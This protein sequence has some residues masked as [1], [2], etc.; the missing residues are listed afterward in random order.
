M[1]SITLERS[2]AY[3]LRNVEIKKECYNLVKII[4]L[5]IIDVT[6]MDKKM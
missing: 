4:G 6:V 2:L 5:C 3:E 1:T